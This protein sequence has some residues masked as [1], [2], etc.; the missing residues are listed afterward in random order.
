L[1]TKGA[2]VP[3]PNNE[4]E[5]GPESFVVSNRAAP[6]T[7]APRYV[8]DLEVSWLVPSDLGAV[9]LLAR[10]QV[11]V[12]RRGCVLRLHRV[13]GG[14]AELLDFVGLSDVMNLCPCRDR[15]CG[16]TRLVDG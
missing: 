15:G 9:D 4:H 6:S 10:L 1:P 3:T 5:T 11:A 16:A 2:T 8:V 14:L 7:K 13:D 12:S